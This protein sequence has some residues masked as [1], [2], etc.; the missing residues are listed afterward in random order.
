MFY[1]IITVTITD[2]IIKLVKRKRKKRT[3]DE[4]QRG[5]SGRIKILFRQREYTEED[6][7]VSNKQHIRC[8]IAWV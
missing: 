7:G 5:V 2:I 6:F 4:T 1:D 3:S 8:W